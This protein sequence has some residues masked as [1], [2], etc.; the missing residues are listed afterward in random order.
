MTR[1]AMN[2]TSEA[3]WTPGRHPALFVESA[4]GTW[5]A[6]VNTDEATWSVRGPDPDDEAH[7]ASGEATNADVA[8][9]SALDL[10]GRVAAAKRQARACIMGQ[11]AA[12]ETKKTKAILEAEIAAALAE[13]DAGITADAQ[14]RFVRRGDRFRY[15]GDVWQVTRVGRGPRGAVT[16]AREIPDPRDRFEKVTLIDDREFP[17]S[18]LREMTKI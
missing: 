1:V 14:A 10:K 16:M 3:K 17:R 11:I 7:Y 2:F 4:A 5:K 8:E 12:T 18:E 13:R 6:M 9:R 15:V